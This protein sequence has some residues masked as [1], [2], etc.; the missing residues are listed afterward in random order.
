MRMNKLALHLFA[1]AALSM[2]PAICKVARAQAQATNEIIYEHDVEMRTRDGVTLKADIFRPKSPGRYP[3]LLNRTPYNKYIYLSDGFASA[4]RGY[5]FII[6]DARGRFASQGD[7]YPFRDEGADTYDTVE[8][9]A[10]L[11][12]SNGKVAMVG[13][14][15]VGVPQMLGA[16]EAPPHLVAIYPGL[17]GSNYHANWAYQGGAFSQYFSENWANSMALNALTRRAE[18][19]TPKVEWWKSHHRPA[20]YP[21]LDPG[22]PSGISDFLH[23]WIAHPNYDAYWKQWSV[24]ERYEKIKVPALHVGAWYDLFLDGTLK[25][26]IGIKAKGGSTAARQGQRLVVIPGGHAGFGRKIGEVDFGE[27]AAFDV[28]AYGMRWFDWILKGIDDGIS[29]EKPVR[30][31]VMGRNIWRD[32]DD[33]PLARAKATRFY[34]HSR[35]D[36]NSLSGH[37]RLAPSP[38]VSEPEDRYVY[39]PTNPVPTVGGVTWQMDDA[40]HYSA[41]PR[42]QRELE[43]RTDILVYTTDA[44][45]KDTEVTGPIQ[46]ELYAK[47]STVDT[48]FTG[49]LID[50]WPNGFAQDLTDGI[51]RARFR[52]STEKPQLMVPGQIYRL[53]IDLGATSNVFLA[54]HKLRLEVSSS[55][56]PRFDRNLNTADSPETGSVAARASIDVLH[57]AAH[58][59]ALVLPVIP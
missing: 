34:L 9:A 46:L 30:L 38:P 29:R 28:W 58:R 56:Y 33:W 51:L 50:V 14:S 19:S 40:G 32:E 25:N 44:F 53:S 26:Y 7:W 37:G 41:G 11:P 47:S 18:K 3:T 15:Y 48:D 39:D 43:K 23:D 16:A 52:D 55:N 12:Y 4:A 42:D 59:S 2:T 27:S 10:Q 17:T 57:D 13:I 6:Q 20:D 22:P 24:E 36:A 1:L 21:I 8:W 54:G 35:G 5:V 31:F 45:R 49:K